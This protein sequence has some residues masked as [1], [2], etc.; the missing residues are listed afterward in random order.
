MIHVS[1]R[2]AALRVRVLLIRRVVDQLKFIE[3]IILD[4]IDEKQ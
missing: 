3:D 1:Q 2:E 4:R